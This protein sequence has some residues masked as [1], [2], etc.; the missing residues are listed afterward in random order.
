[1]T[2]SNPEIYPLARCA[3]PNEIILW[4]DPP[5]KT[6]VE[7]RAEPADAAASTVPRQ[8]DTSPMQEFLVT[9]D[10][11]LTA[12][13]DEPAWAV[14]DLLPT[15]LT[16]LAGKPKIGKSW[17]ALQVAR[18][19]ATG[20]PTFGRPVKRAPILY[21]ALEDPPRRL[22]NRMRKQGWPLGTEADFMTIGEFAYRLGNL[23][24][25]GPHLAKQIEE[26]GYRY[27][28]IDT[29]SRAAR[30]SQSDVNQMT[31]A[32]SPVQ[33]VA[34]AT[35]CAVVVV[36]HHRKNLSKN[37]DAI[38]DILGSTAK[39]AMA[40]CIWGIYRGRGTVGTMLK[41]IGREVAE[42]VL[43][44]TFDART[45]CWQYDGNPYELKL[46]ERRQEI[47]DALQAMG[48]SSLGD[49]VD[50]VGQPKGN[51]HKRLQDLVSAGLVLRIEKGRRVYYTLL[52]SDL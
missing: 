41:I 48:Q 10:E 9:A 17:L 20:D 43:K 35:D 39:G 40:D 1:M 18:S 3:K 4:S 29:L 51:T 2:E 25:G 7:E 8:P 24:D 26:R 28:V 15:G 37:S 31:R 5:E 50:F 34:H 45:G 42:S 36:D 14:P 23:A 33:E 21:L 44:L 13:W 11:L 12:E 52:E 16:I 19:V 32:L 38:T 46:T 27:V 22:S 30:G 6:L 47:I 49:I